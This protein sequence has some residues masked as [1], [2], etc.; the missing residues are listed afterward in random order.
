MWAVASADGT[1]L[2]LCDFVHQRFELLVHI[3]DPCGSIG[4]RL[5]RRGDVGLDLFC[6]DGYLATKK[7]KKKS[8]FNKHGPSSSVAVCVSLC[9]VFTLTACFCS[10]A[11]CFCIFA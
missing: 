1:Y 6:I 3:V 10:A 8:Y 5:A 4:E 7:S 9:W 11:F 2:T